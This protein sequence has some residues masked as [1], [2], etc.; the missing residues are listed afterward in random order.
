VRRP[1]F[2]ALHLAACLLVAPIARGQTPEAKLTV[3]VV[4]PTGGLLPTATVTVTGQGP[5]TQQI[6]INPVATSDKGVAVFEHLVPGLY[7]LEA[8]LTQFNPT[9][10]KDVQLKSGD[11]TR[12]V[13]LKL[14]GGTFAVTV[15]EDQQTA[16]SDRSSVTFGS[17]LTNEQVQALS[18]DPTELQRQIQAWADPMP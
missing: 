10:V 11:N 5:S 13:A 16:A 6:V 17:A 9:I 4:D 3:T 1:R 8:D 2:L 14:K 7:T 15:I 18:D 12:T